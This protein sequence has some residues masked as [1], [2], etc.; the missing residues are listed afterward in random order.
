MSTSNESKKIGAIMDN[1][2]SQISDYIESLLRCEPP[3]QRKYAK[4]EPEPT[5]LTLKERKK[6]LEKKK[7]KKK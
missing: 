5:G 1:Q 2:N 6:I 3:P 7:A 4:A